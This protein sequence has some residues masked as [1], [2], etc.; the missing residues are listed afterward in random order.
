M[1]SSAGFEPATFRLGGERSIQLSYEDM[2]AHSSAQALTTRSAGR[3]GV[4]ASGSMDQTDT[5][6]HV[7]FKTIGE[8]RIQCVELEQHTMRVRSH[9]RTLAP[10]ARKESSIDQLWVA[11]FE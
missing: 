3:R 10:T 8:N 6:Q 9:S 5:M 11:E 4:L 7:L 2:A 1:A